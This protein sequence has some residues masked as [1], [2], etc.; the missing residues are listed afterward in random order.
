[1][2]RKT[3]SRPDSAPLLRDRT[4][5][6]SASSVS[7]RDVQQHH[8][9]DAESLAQELRFVRRQLEVSTAAKARLGTIAVFQR[10]DTR[11]VYPE[12]SEWAEAPA[13]AGPPSRATPSP[14]CRP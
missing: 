9:G 7:G 3:P 4:Q 8:G 6:V 2:P 11:P 1:M 5:H 13:V 14:K 10:L 12:S